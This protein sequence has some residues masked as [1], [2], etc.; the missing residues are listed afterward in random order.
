[1]FLKH[2]RS[3]E[4]MAMGS[5]ML[6]ERYNK[7]KENFFEH[8]D[9]YFGHGE[10]WFL[11]LSNTPNL[12]LNNLEIKRA[13]GKN[14]KPSG[15]FWAAA[16][17]HWARYVANFW[18]NT[19]NGKAGE[20]RKNDIHLYKIKI[21]LSKVIVGNIEQVLHRY[22]I[23]SSWNRYSGERETIFDWEKIAHEGIDVGATKRI[24]KTVPQQM[25]NGKT[26]N[27]KKTVFEHVPKIIKASGV[28]FTGGD[29]VS[30]IDVDSI[31]I[32]DKSAI[33]E[34]KYMG[35]YSKALKTT[36]REWKP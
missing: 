3:Y 18:H 16:R 13:Y 25:K 2:L 21:D 32:W 17:T 4:E 22:K 23:E 15:G 1:M 27:V 20:P 9:R 30:A 6:R 28:W 31:C 5:K 36:G 34:I 12:T 11:H 19:D 14:V 8:L 24:E 26:R 10:Q 33:K 7:T 29:V 35:D